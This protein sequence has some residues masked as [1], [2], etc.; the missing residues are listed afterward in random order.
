LCSLEKRI[1]YLFIYL[2]LPYASSNFDFLFIIFYLN[3]VDIYEDPPTILVRA[4]KISFIFFHLSNC[5]YRLMTFIVKLRL[6]INNIYYLFLSSGGI[7]ELFF[8][9]EINL[10][11]H[12][13]IKLL[14]LCCGMIFIVKLFMNVKITD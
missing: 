7:L 5:F 9:S 10:V 1:I 8:I 11:N 3:T 13:E 12:L 6:I 2:F 4:R 14:K